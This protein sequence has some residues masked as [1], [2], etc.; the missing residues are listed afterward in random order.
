M[1]STFAIEVLLMFSRTTVLPGWVTAKYG[2]AGADMPEGW[3][4][5]VG[6]GLIGRAACRGRGEISGG[7]GLFKKKK[8]KIGV[9]RIN[10]RRLLLPLSC[11]AES[12]MSLKHSRELVTE[13]VQWA[14][15]GGQKDAG[16]EEVVFIVLRCAPMMIH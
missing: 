11:A 6:F 1:F 7:G 5:G 15:I 10:T 12:N 4:L 14:M 13:S 3:L 8:K 16:V 9:I 2:S